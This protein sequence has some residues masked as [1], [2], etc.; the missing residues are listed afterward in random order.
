MDKEIIKWIDPNGTEFKIDDGENYTLLLGIKGFHMPPISTVENEVP[1]QAG[2]RLRMVKVK[3][4]ELDVPIVI[5]GKD[6]IEVRNNIR[7]LLRFLNPLKGDGRLHVSFY[8]AS[9]RELSCRYI[10]G[11][12]IDEK[13]GSKGEN[14][15]KAILVFRAFDPFWYDTSTK[16]ETFKTGEQVAT[17]FPIFPLRLSSSSVFADVTIDNTG[18]VETWPE[19]IITGPGENILLRNLTTGEVINLEHADAKLQAGESITIDTKSGK[20]S[21]TRNDGTNLFYTLSEESSLWALQEGSNSIR[22]EMSNTTTES[23]VQLTY[24]NRYW[25]P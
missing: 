1:N 20:K 17:F 6:E 18:D 19:W 23:Q 22:I 4:R 21:V 5:R 2:S 25:G 3:A 13:R 7:R 14:W 16:V 12:E 10:G 9:Q 15:Q 8:G 11:L 24:R